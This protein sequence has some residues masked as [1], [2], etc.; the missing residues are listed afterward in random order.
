MTTPVP[1]PDPV[2]STP[3]VDGTVAEALAK[4]LADRRSNDSIWVQ[5]L[6]E[7][8]ALDRAVYQAVAVTPT[9]HLD[10]PFRRLSRSTDG[11]VLW[12]A[13]AGG[14]ALTR[15]KRGRQVA[16]EGVASLAATAVMVNVGAKSLVRR[17]RPDRAGNDSAPAR[18][19]PHPSTTSFPSGHSA[20]SFAFAYTI[21]R[22]LPFLGIPIRLVAAAV[23]YS[24]VHTGVHYPGDVIV[25]SIMGAGTAATVEAVWDRSRKGAA[26]RPGRGALRRGGRSLA[27]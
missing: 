9:T 2:A 26:A 19:V 14:L 20:T 24:R 18:R 23:A 27:P 12:L 16:L 5:M 15:G 1:P 11:G 25:G 6:L 7:L 3:R 10:V 13:M 22:H 8:G 21:G 17:R 4:P